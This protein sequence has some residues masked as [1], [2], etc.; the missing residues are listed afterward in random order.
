M[1]LTGLVACRSRTCEAWVGGDRELVLRGIRHTRPVNTSGCDGTPWCRWV[2]RGQ[3][4]RPFLARLRAADHAGARLPGDGSY[5]A[6]VV[7]SGTALSAVA[8]MFVV[9]IA[10]FPNSVLTSERNRLSAESWNWY[11]LACATVAHS[12]VG[13]AC[14]CLAPLAGFWRR[15]ARSFTGF[16]DL[17]LLRTTRLRD[18]AEAS[19]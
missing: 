19:S 2:R 11:A 7:P 3:D 8:A 1:V 6:V 17:A 16:V 18:A 5:A 13:S 9:S 12:N 4:A 10:R 15:G 14:R